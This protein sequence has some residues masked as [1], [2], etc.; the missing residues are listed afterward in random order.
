MDD[1][2]INKRL[3]RIVVEA[4]LIT[5]YFI[6]IFFISSRFLMELFLGGTMVLL[7]RMGFMFNKTVG[8]LQCWPRNKKIIL[9]ICSIVPL[10]EIAL[11]F[12]I[13]YMG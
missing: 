6:S 9:L 4:A 3:N 1:K 2:E 12:L 10:I 13:S 7:F 5:I 8:Y 11:L